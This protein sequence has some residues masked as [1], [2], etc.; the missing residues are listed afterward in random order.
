[1]TKFEERIG[2][3]FNLDELA[4]E[5][6]HKYQIGNL[7]ECKLID[8]GYE[9]FNFALTTDKIKVLVKVY[10]NNRADDDCKELVNRQLNPFKNGFKCPKIY[11]NSDKKHLSMFELNNVKFR[12]CVM[13]FID[14]LDFF[15]LKQLPTIEELKEIAKQL[16][17]L[18]KVPYKPKYIYD[19]WSIINFATEYEKY[20]NYVPE[21]LKLTFKK[22]Y[23]DFKCINFDKLKYGY[24]HGDIIETNIIKDRNN[25][26]YYIDFSVANY[27]PVIIDMAVTIC[28][29]C[30]DINS[31]QKSQQRIDAFV[32]SYLTQTKLTDYELSTL[33]LFLFVHQAQTV[34]Q[35]NKELLIEGNDSKENL[36]FMDKGEKG[37]K[38]L[39]DITFDYSKKS[40]LIKNEQQK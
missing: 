34:L 25:E 13:E 4:R 19:R 9:D 37:I 29:I 1:M 32:K 7:I 21:D 15:R 28:D 16:A 2:L 14:G 31:I 17:I 22:I 23:D 11:E 3:N 12:L 6:C 10:A 8:V 36:A 20:N 5:I 24:V 30:I 18:N 35:T 38:L 27:L 26:L 40:K 33:K 39:K